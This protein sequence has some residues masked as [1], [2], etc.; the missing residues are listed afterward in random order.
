MFRFARDVIFGSVASDPGRQMAQ[1]RISRAVIG[2]AAVRIHERSVIMNRFAVVAGFAI[3][4]ALPLGATA[5]DQHVVAQSD[6]ITWGAGP[7]AL[8][9]G[10][11]IAVLFG[12]PAK[13]PAHMH[14]NDENVTVL[15]GTLHIG[16]GDKLDE[17]KGE[18]LGAGGY[19]HMPKGMHH[20]AWFSEDTIIQLNGVGPT[21][22]TYLNPAD[23]PR[24]T[25]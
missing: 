12:D 2:A 22:I 7:P 17:T 9:K 11:Q 20:Y 5:D 8:P 24:K 25:N 23:D 19:L 1:R 18:A 10:A 4:A 13:V 3:A 6:S 15:S 21:G 14:P 16:T